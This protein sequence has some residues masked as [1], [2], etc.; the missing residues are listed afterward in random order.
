M[1]PAVKREPVTKA[2][3]KLERGTIVVKPEPTTSSQPEGE[4]DQQLD[5]KK[6]QGRT[7]NTILA[8]DSPYSPLPERK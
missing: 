1:T 6:E 7:A 2:A 3:I 8:A 5:V 4:N